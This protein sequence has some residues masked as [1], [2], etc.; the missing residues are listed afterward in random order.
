MNL[1]YDFTVTV[2]HPD[3]EIHIC[4]QH[5]YELKHELC[6]LLSEYGFGRVIFV[7]QS[8]FENEHLSPLIDR[9]PQPFGD[10]SITFSVNADDVRGDING[11]LE[12]GLYRYASFVTNNYHYNIQTSVQRTYNLIPAPRDEDEINQR[13][14]IIED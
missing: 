9:E 1:F 10:V 5:V 4:N 6:R 14:E 13:N 7:G 11:F 2:Y 3:V 12:A 8:K